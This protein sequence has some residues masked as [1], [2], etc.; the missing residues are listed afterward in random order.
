MN[1]NAGHD[2]KAGYG[3]SH[4]TRKGKE[5]EN[6]MT[7]HHACICSDNPLSPGRVLGPGAARPSQGGQEGFSLLEPRVVSSQRGLCPVDPLHH[8]ISRQGA[9]CGLSTVPCPPP[10]TGGHV[11]LVEVGWPHGST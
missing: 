4:K 7:T 3:D 11:R 10:T 1:A 6:A 9:Y 8:P 5:L 2:R